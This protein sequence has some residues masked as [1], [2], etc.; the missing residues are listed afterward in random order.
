M[1]HQL[2][3]FIKEFQLRRT[4]KSFAA[5]LLTLFTLTFF[6]SCEEPTNSGS[7]EA[8]LKTPT[9]SELLG[10]WNSD[11]VTGQSYTFEDG[12]GKITSSVGGLTQNVNFDWDIDGD[13]LTMGGMA[14]TVSM[15]GSKLYLETSGT[16]FTFTKKGSESGGS[17]GSGGGTT[18]EKTPTEKELLGSWYLADDSQLGYGLTYTFAQNGIMIQ[19]VTIGET[20]SDASC[21]W[22]L[23]RDKLSITNE[24]TVT[25]TVSMEG[26]ELYLKLLGETQIFY[27]TGTSGGTGGSGTGGTDKDLTKYQVFPGPSTSMWESLIYGSG[28]NRADISSV[29]EAAG[30][31]LER[32]EMMA[33][34]DWQTAQVLLPV[35]DYNLTGLKGVEIT[36]EVE[37]YD[38]TL[39]FFLGIRNEDY[40]GVEGSYGHIYGG[41]RAVLT[42][43]AKYPG[44]IVTDTLYLEDFSL[45]WIDEEEAYLMD[46]NMNSDELYTLADNLQALEVRNSIGFGSECDQSWNR[47]AESVQFIVHE[48]NMLGKNMDF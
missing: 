38:D 47:K 20:S 12:T 42:H 48:I 46:F 26:N 9:A 11:D 2:L 43:G 40:L 32:D 19:T 36:Y 8:V 35:T 17:G 22:K 39:A 30:I 7:K 6:T 14:Y 31:T 29:G 21:S 15:K 18:G 5:L 13:Q 1:N 16:T 45:N 3:H 44:D 24:A 41:F 23:S 4:Q 25:Y 28:R 10:T 37:S 34:D 27:K 33:A